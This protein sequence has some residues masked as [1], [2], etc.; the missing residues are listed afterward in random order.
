MVYGL[1]CREENVVSPLWPNWLLEGVLSL[2]LKALNL[3]SQELGHMPGSETEA[4]S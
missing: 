2:N 1:G 3:L 4:P